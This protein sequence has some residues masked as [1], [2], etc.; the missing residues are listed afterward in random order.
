MTTIKIFQ[1]SF[2]IAPKVAFFQQQTISKF[3]N[4][5]KISKKIFE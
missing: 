2:K 3:L 5:Q 4:E 1:S